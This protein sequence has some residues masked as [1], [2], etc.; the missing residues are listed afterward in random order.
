MWNLLIGLVSGSSISLLAVHYFLRR[1]ARLHREMKERHRRDFQELISRVYHKDQ[2]PRAAR[3]C[4]LSNLGLPATS[5]LLDLQEKV[6]ILLLRM[7]NQIEMF[8]KDHHVGWSIFAR[9]SLE[10]TINLHRQS[11]TESA[12]IKEYWRLIQM[13]SSE[14]RENVISTVKEF[15]DLQ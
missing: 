15:E 12:D 1:Y 6:L 11:M 5:K 10:E 4:G 2:V 9:E 3:I 13:V 7:F 14:H 8:G